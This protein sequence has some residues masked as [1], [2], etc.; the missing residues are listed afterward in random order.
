[1]CR[2]RRPPSNSCIATW[3]QPPSLCQ[4][5][6]NT[7]E[8]QG[9][10]WRMQALFWT[11]FEIPAGSKFIRQHW[12][13]KCVQFLIKVLWKKSNVQNW[14]RYSIQFAGH[15]HGKQ[16][17]WWTSYTSKIPALTNVNQLGPT[18]NSCRFL[19]YFPVGVQSKTGT[20]FDR[21]KSLLNHWD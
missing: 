4:P 12:C 8:S 3:H 9:P 20:K 2:V 14:S 10:C 1:M 11:V 19:L 18:W 15:Q 17:R 6:H 16:E 13:E 5:H 21:T 7:C